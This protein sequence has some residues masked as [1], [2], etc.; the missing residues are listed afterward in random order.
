MAAPL[1]NEELV[2]QYGSDSSTRTGDS[3]DQIAVQVGLL[4]VVIDD[5]YKPELVREEGRI[6]RSLSLI[7]HRPKKM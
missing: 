5:K 3:K 1:K 6:P 4:D 2:K 7:L